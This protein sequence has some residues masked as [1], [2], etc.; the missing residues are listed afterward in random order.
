MEVDKTSDGR[1]KG[2]QQE[3]KEARL[4][5][6][7]I[8]SSSERRYQCRSALKCCRLRTGYIISC[9]GPWKVTS[10][11]RSVLKMGRGGCS[12]SNLRCFSVLPA[13]RVNTC[14]LLASRCGFL[15]F[16]LRWTYGGLRW[17]R[18]LRFSIKMDVT[19]TVDSS[20]SAMWA[21][22]PCLSQQCGHQNETEQSLDQS[23]DTTCQSLTPA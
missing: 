18:A 12:G 13:P 23:M 1:L 22:I 2:A 10:P 20:S 5:D 4:C 19:G 16:I 14:S 6:L 8:T 9:P 21:S 3:G 17:G 7:I 11:P 15:G